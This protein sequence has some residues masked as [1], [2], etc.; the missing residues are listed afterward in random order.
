MRYAYI[1]LSITTVVILFVFPVFG[2][3]PTFTFN[4]L[5]YDTQ[6]NPRSL[7]LG[8]SAMAVDR[9][10]A[11][12]LYNPAG[13]A[14]IKGSVFVF[15]AIESVDG[16]LWEADR[17][18]I[19]EALSINKNAIIAFSKRHTKNFEF[20]GVSNESFTYNTVTFA[21]E[22][23]PNLKL[24]INWNRMYTTYKM[25]NFYEGGLSKKNSNSYSL[26]CGVLKQFQFSRWNHSYNVQIGMSIHNITDSKIELYGKLRNFAMPGG[27]SNYNSG[28]LE[29][30]LPET[31]YLGVSYGSS[32]NA[33]VGETSLKMYKW[34]F[35][36]N[37][38]Q[39]LNGSIRDG[40]SLGTE[41]E[42]WE[43]IS[44]RVGHFKEKL[45]NYQGETQQKYWKDNTFGAGLM[46]PVNK[47]SRGKIPVQLH[48]DY[49][50]Q[51]LPNYIKGTGYYLNKSRNFSIFSI[52][53]YWK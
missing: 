22:P 46:I 44:I 17:Y 40:Y 13:L 19:G 45:S 26:D 8:K 7:A 32:A 49:T 34:L 23:I 30:V 39:E 50:E 27:I 29:T 51:E 2:Q 53:V 25:Y 11:S 35:V 12:V 36:G 6:Y 41:L 43:I 4:E 33:T 3:Y 1:C 16:P 15:S 37:L 10:L 24:G 9:G 21:Y 52:N 48:L 20:D 31:M 28:S 14:H 42:I 18:M 47:F 5:F 38:Q